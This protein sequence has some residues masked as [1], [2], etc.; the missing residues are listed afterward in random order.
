M[1]LGGALSMKPRF[2]HIRAFL[3]TKMALEVCDVTLS[4]FNGVFSVSLNT[5]NNEVAVC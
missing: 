4:A 5:V 2:H 1:Y 3:D